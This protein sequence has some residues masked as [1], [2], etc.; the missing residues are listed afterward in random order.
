MQQ[1]SDLNRIERG[2][3]PELI[4]G[5]PKRE[6][7]FEHMAQQKGSVQFS[8]FFLDGLCYDWTASWSLWRVRLGSN[9]QERVT[10]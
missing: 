3:L 9:M 6:S 4:A 1:L 10:M 5:H 7:V 8:M 2:A